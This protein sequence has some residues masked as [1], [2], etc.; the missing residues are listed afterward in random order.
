MNMAY[1]VVILKEAEREYHSIVD[2]LSN[3]LKSKQAA[4]NFINE[5]DKQVALISSNPDIFSLSKL[6]EVEAL[7]YR[8]AFINKYV[9]LYKAEE[10]LV[11]I[12]H[13]F[14][15]TQDYARLV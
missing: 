13:I 1:K 14:H 3:I 11:I 10:N 9:M 12:A 6:P 7:G 8:S 2:Y 15:Q 4:K 5:F